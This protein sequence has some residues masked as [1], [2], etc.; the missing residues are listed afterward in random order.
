MV[1]EMRNQTKILME[2]LNKLAKDSAEIS[3]TNKEDIK[4]ALR[5]ISETTENLNKIIYRLENGKGTLGKLLTDE[6]VY[7]NIRDA[8]IFAKD[9][10]EM[11]KK[12]PNKLFFSEEQ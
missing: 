10:F 1:Y 5:N 4:I 6:E 9:L 3:N 7:N 12:D 11:L 2:E 8:S